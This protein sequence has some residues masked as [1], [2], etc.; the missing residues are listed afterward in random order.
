M[1][2]PPPASRKENKNGTRA[3]VNGDHKLALH[4][5]G[6]GGTRALVDGDH[7][8]AV[9]HEGTKVLS[10]SF[11]QQFNSCRLISFA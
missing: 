11:L 4:H 9:H 1:S 5:E 6:T 3:L 7:K 2:A 10:S 8:L